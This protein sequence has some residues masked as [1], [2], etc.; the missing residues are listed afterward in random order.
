MEY[1]SIF[2]IVGLFLF[3]FMGLFVPLL[4]ISE[5]ILYINMSFM[6]AVVII[7]LYAWLYLSVIWCGIKWLKQ[8]CPNGC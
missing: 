5:W 7:T 4:K 1:V 3:A 6:K 8:F 2:M